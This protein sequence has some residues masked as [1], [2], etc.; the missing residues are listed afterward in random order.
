M[1]RITQVVNKVQRPL[2]D[3]GYIKIIDVMGSDQSIIEAARM[4]TDGAFRGWGPTCE[5]CGEKVRAAIAHASPGAV[6]CPNHGT[7][8]GKPGDEKLLSYLYKNKHATPFEFAQIVFEIQCP[9]M[10]TR[11][12]HRHRTQGYNEMSA[13]YEPL[14]DLYY[15]PSVE[16]LMINASKTN[17]QAGTVQDAEALTEARAISFR[18][19]LQQQYDV[20][21]DS[22]LSALADGVPKELARCGM[23]VGHYTRFRATANLRNWLGFMTLRSSEKAQW[24]IR[25]YSLAINKLLTEA[26]PRTMWLF[27]ADD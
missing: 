6:K 7:V 5:H 8:E 12:W 2:L 21:E 3:H 4:S 25:Q 23:P 16:R 11:E 27:N 1:P 9:I 14:P 10:V 17:K 26:F 19:E 20:F 22:Y 24:E 18:Q 15:L 13:R